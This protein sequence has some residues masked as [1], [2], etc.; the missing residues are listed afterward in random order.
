MARYRKVVIMA[1]E[2]VVS[3]AKVLEMIRSEASTSMIPVMFLTGKSDKE[4]VM[5]VLALKPVKYLLKSMQPKD[6]VKEIDDFFAEQ[7]AA[8]KGGVA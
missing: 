6:W 4:T 1:L 5:K 8:A 7:K 3:G 2:Q